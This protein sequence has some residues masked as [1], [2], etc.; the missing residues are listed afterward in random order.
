M[1]K[2]S[3]FQAVTS[4]T[5]NIFSFNQLM[6]RRM[7][8]IQK[9]IWFLSNSESHTIEFH[10]KDYLIEVLEVSDVSGVYIGAIY[11]MCQ[12]YNCSV[13]DRKEMSTAFEVSKGLKQISCLF[14]IY[15]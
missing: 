5:D 14:K 1:E 7:E 15:I 10:L 9:H 2:Q 13:K 6:Q 4:Y 11:D 12:G 8:G 3:G